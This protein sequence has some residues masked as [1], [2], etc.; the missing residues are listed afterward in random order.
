MSAKAAGSTPLPPTN[1]R[2]RERGMECPQAQAPGRRLTSLD[3]QPQG[4]LTE[5]GRSVRPDVVDS[6]P[7]TSLTR[8]G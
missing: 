4:R 5:K 6:G 3:C 2:L 8:Q 7:G 1:R